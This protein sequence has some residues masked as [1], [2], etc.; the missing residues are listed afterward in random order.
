MYEG[1][2]ACTLPCI[3]D[4]M[5]TV[6]VAGNGASPMDQMEEYL[7]SRRIEKVLSRE[8]SR[9]YKVPVNRRK[10][11]ALS[12]TEPNPWSTGH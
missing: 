1:Q 7:R 3:R 2:I 6:D 11:R 4:G 12:A 5:Y 8:Q 9:V 10:Q